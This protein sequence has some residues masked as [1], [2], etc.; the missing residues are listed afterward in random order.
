MKKVFFVLLVVLLSIPLMGCK[1]PEDEI[2]WDQLEF[3]YETNP[4][5]IGSYEL[6]RSNYFQSWLEWGEWE[7][8]VELLF[9]K[10]ICFGSFNWDDSGTFR[11]RFDYHWE[12][13]NYWGRGCLKLV[14]NK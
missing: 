12:P 3:E 8:E 6:T 5:F 7:T 1:T 9:S 10:P 4:A 13:I 2:P 14:K 11:V